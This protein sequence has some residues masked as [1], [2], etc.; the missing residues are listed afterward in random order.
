MG[1]GREGR[2]GEGIHFKNKFLGSEGPICMS[3][4]LILLSSV[5]GI[6]LLEVNYV[7]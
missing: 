5:L 7:N 2:E 1:V 4:F 3:G 6:L